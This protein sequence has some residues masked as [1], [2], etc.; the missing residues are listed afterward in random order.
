VRDNQI[1]AER[2]RVTTGNTTLSDEE[3]SNAD[4]FPG[5]GNLFSNLNME[6]TPTLLLPPTPPLLILHHMCFYVSHFNLY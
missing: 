4:F 2:L 5:I 3:F 6:T 1:F